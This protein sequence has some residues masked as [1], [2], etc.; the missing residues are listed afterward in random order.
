MLKC[1]EQSPRVCSD[2]SIRWYE[3]DT[4]CLDFELTF[5]DELDNELE[6]T[7]NDKI[8]ICFTEGLYGRVIFTA[9]AVG[10][11]TLTV[12]IDEET[13]KLFKAGVYKY[14]VRRES[15]Y[16]TTVMRYNKVVVE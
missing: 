9:E 14:C 3:G 11:N 13:T 12:N 16:T 4:F 8:S 6:A 7:P 10:T 1:A 2:G 15:I 5:T